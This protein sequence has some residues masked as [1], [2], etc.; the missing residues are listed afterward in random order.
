MISSLE[1]WQFAS[2][3]GV[4]RIRQQDHALIQPMFAVKLQTLPNGK[5]KPVLVK[6]F[7]PGNLMP[8]VTPFPG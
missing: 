2:A 5:Q 3:K 7:S 8:P 4:M 6:R 1:G